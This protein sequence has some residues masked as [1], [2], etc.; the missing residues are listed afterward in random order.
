MIVTVAAV[1]SQATTVRGELGGKAVNVMLDSG[2]SVSLVESNTLTGM[3]DVVGVQCAK[4][5]R[6][7]TASGDQLP[8]LKHIR[9]CVKLGEF[10]VMHDFVVVDSL[11]TPV[12]LGIDFLQQNGLVLDFT[13]TP[14]IVRK[15]HVTAG[16][17]ADH[18]AL[19]Q[20]IPIFE[21]AHLN[22]AHLCM[23]QSQGE[24]EN[25]VVD[26]C[27]IPNYK[28]PT[29]F[30]TPKCGNLQLEGIV[31]SFKVIFCT[32]PGKTNDAYHYIHTSGNPIRVPPRR[33]PAHYQT[34]VMQQLKTMLE[35]GIIVHSKS[36]WMAPAVFVPKKS[37]QLRI[38]VD[39]RELNK[40]TTK[41]SY[42]LPLPDEVQDRLAGSIIFSTLDLHSGYWQLPVNP[43]DR[44]K[45]A[46][47]PGPGMGL[48]EF[49]RM[50]FGLTGAP[51]SFQRL[52][53]KTLQ[54]LP[55]VTIY[56]DDILVHSDSVETHA[57]HLKVV[58]QRIRDAGLTLRGSKCHIRLS[59]V[60]YLGHVFS[61]KGMSADPSKVQDIT[62]WPVPTNA[63]EV[64]QFLG[65]ASYYR[66]YIL[67]FSNIAA[68]L[69]FLT[70]K[71]VLF[72]WDSKCEETFQ[73]LKAHL[74]QA[75]VL[76]YPCFDSTAEEFVLQT[77]ASA[78]GLGAILEQDGH[79]IGYASR[80]LT[81]SERNYSVVQRECLAIVFGLKQFRHYLLGKSFRLYTDHAP[82]QWLAEQKMEGMLFRW[83]LA[84]Q[85]YSFKIV[86][87]K[88][89]AN[90]NAD[91]LSRLPSIPCALTVSLPPPQLLQAQLEDP[92]ISLVRHA[93]L[94]S[95]NAP[96]DKQWSRPPLRRF[97]QLW[98]QL[99]VADGDTL[100]RK[101]A[102]GPLESVVTVPVLP[103]SLQQE[104]LKLSHDVPT[105]GHQGVEKTLEKLRRIA[106][107][108][109][110]AR[111]VEQ[112]C[113]TC[114]TCQQSKLSMPPRSPLQNI[115]IGQP[116]QMVA[117]DI[118]QV[119]LSTNNN[120]YL[121][122][123]QDYFTKWADAVPLPDQTASRI[124]TALIRF[125]CTYGPPQILHSDQGRNFES[126]IFTQVLQAFGV[127]KSRTT[128]Y[129]PQGDGMVERFNRTLMQLLRA[130]V[131]SESDW[132]TYLPQ[133]L[134]AYRTARHSSTGA[135]PYLLVYG[136]DPPALQGTTQSAYDSLSYPAV[137]QAKLAELQDFVHANL[138]QAASNQKAAYDQ[139]TSSASFKQGEPVWLSVPT[140]GKLEPKWEGGWVVKS[141]K[142]PVN[143][144]ICD[145]KRTKVVHINRVRHCYVPG[146][147]DTA[148]Q[149]DQR[150][151][152]VYNKWSPPEIE[153]L[154]L[155]PAEA[156]VEP[157]RRY[158]GRHHRPP[159]RY[160]P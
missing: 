44:E 31:N 40:R 141:L 85:E 50:P 151:N 84:M 17:A 14:V 88:G 95:S 121:L 43:A 128:P 134:Y 58:F 53:D 146:T 47:C 94:Q 132:E 28:G 87:R 111:D 120:K 6:L 115:P 65:L 105:A 70:Q 2:S 143:L 26:E 140:A 29:E 30:D 160:R 55:F 149:S 117:V 108:V 133:V 32:T 46:F 153:H 39:Y 24:L 74:V 157:I 66:R 138:A 122:V 100:C 8:I 75:P 147:L 139:H 80:S 118:L 78:V 142:G 89:S 60:R 96:S 91:A 72:K 154:V 114:T 86:Y 5:L 129:H 109:N 52:I 11:V 76:A 124:V 35:Q 144:E 37:G 27:A 38:C 61:A 49:C 93:V 79:V 116:W 57:Q 69:H 125:F 36:P 98:Q 33:V 15:G 3:K 97:K 73:A 68:P 104:A 119:P 136:R 54:G 13:C 71:D 156:S 123:L 42:P 18:V 7:V 56:L 64:R 112:Y 110:M 1:R 102:P 145:D 51:S 34:E 22:Q 90:T 113:R 20:V 130:Y 62:D 103:P 92:T 67:N 107:W 21:N 4:S 63:T 16:I 23:I 106:Y 25:D 137:V 81:S 48:Y 99:L 82:L 150:E 135:S 77:D 152:E 12:I 126:T 101:Y 83:A 158:P 159:D 127:R 10:N 45:T 9:T 155:P 131:T 148:A 41:D 59:S 19:V